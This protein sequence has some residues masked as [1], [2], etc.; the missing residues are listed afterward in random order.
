MSGYFHFGPFTNY[1][2][3]WDLKLTPWGWW[4]V[5]SRGEGDGL[6]VYISNDATPPCDDNRGLTLFR[7]YA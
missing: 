1:G 2:W 6:R 3:G 5:W 7:W 4:L